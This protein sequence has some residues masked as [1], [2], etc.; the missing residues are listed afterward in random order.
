MTIQQARA[1]AKNMLPAKR[2]CHT[3]NVAAAA[4]VLALRFGASPEKAELAAW[5]HDLVK[6]CDRAQ[7]LQLLGQDAI[8]AGS[9]ASRPQPVWHGPACAIYARH[10][11][12]IDDAEV[13]SAIECHTTGKPGMSTLDKVVFLA[14]Y[15]SEERTTPGVDGVRKLAE[16]DLDA[17]VVAA[18]EHSIAWLRS[19]GRKVDTESLAALEWM[20]A[21]GRETGDK[22]AEH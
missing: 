2:Y 12:G 10:Q 5:L 13:L 6:P 8:M 21:Q 9:T 19:T 11:L 16:T 1:K 14:D 15:I 7:L 4:R 20:H 18:M 17:A 22:E 3:K